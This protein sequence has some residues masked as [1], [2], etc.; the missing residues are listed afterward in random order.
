MIASAS[1][2]RRMLPRLDGRRLAVEIVDQHQRAG[3]RGQAEH[4]RGDD[5]R[6]AALV[7]SVRRSA[8]GRRPPAAGRARR[9]PRHR[10]AGRRAGARHRSLPTGQAV[11][12]A[13]PDE[14][15]RGF[16][17]GGE[18]G[19]RRD[20][21]EPRP[22]CRSAR[23]RRAACAGSL[24]RDARAAAR[25]RMSEANSAAASACVQKAIRPPCLLRY[26]Q[27]VRHERSVA[28]LYK[29]MLNASRATRFSAWGGMD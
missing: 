3:R 21:G 6:M 28:K 10:P 22:A 20:R 14:V 17:I 8:A 19:R 24:S 9:R 16:G 12:H 25:H 26:C 2:A 29:E 18:H 13:D 11:E 5:Q 4:D 1:I 7:A 27:F 23:K 15:A